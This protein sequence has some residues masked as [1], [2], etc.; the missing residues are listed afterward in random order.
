M[1]HEYRIYR[2]T[3]FQLGLH[4]GRALLTKFSYPSATAGGVKIDFKTFLE[5]KWE[6]WSTK[7]KLKFKNTCK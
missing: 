3:H 6:D 5:A 2:E 1:L 4:A 7:G